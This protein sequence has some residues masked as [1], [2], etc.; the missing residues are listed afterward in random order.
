VLASGGVRALALLLVGLVA[1]SGFVHAAAPGRGSLV[2]SR[3]PAIQD[4]T[5]RKLLDEYAPADKLAGTLVVLTECFGGDVMDDLQTRPGTTVI[6]GTSPGETGKYGGYDKGAAEAL[7]PGAGRTSDDV[8]KAGSATKKPGET[9]TS[10]GPAFPL[11][12]VDPKNG[13]I[14]S[15]HIIFY[16]GQPN[17]Q[18]ARYRDQIK[19]NFAGEPGTTFTSAGGG[20]PGM[21]GWTYSG[22]KQGLEQALKDVKPK[23]NKNEQLILFVSDHGDLEKAPKTA[24]VAPGS[25]FQVALDA[26]PSQDP[27]ATSEVLVLARGVALNATDLTLTLGDAPPLAAQ[28]DVLDFEGDGQLAQEGEGTLFSFAANLTE[29]TNATISVAPGLPVELLTLDYSVGSVVPKGEDAGAGAATPLPPV[30]A[31]GALALA[32]LALA[33]ARR[34]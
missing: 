18:D 34:R 16:A 11:D 29:E 8:H 19:Q 4:S 24:K 25:K 22:S 26:P 7:K 28:S 12:P 32:A 3:G 27:N 30:L 1:T 5:L 14:K 17:D 15:R 13:P 6:S 21:N 33:A 9:P 20:A 23:L 31:L 10:A 2:T